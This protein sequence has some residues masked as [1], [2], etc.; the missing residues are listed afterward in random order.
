MPKCTSVPNSSTIAT[1]CF[2]VTTPAQFGS[3]IQRQTTQARFKSFTLDR[4]LH[5]NRGSGKA[6]RLNPDGLSGRKGSSKWNSTPSCVQSF[7][8]K[9]NL[10][11]QLPLRKADRDAFPMPCA[12][13]NSSSCS[14]RWNKRAVVFGQVNSRG[15]HG[16]I[17]R[18]SG[19]MSRQ[20]TRRTVVKANQ[21]TYGCVF[22]GV[23]S[24]LGWL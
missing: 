10:A 16:S 13:M 21:N 18:G 7:L 4:T 15:T 14:G 12:Q 5:V 11:V 22:F 23:Y 8:G 19:K 6:K 20:I 1:S 3:N 17:F 2:L 24:F 9:V